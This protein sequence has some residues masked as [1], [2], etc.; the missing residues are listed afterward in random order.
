MQ[1]QALS[2]STGT[3]WAAAGSGSSSGSSPLPFSISLYLIPSSP[4]LLENPAKFNFISQAWIV[5]CQMS[6]CGQPGGESIG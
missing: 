2:T 5:F 4:F 1:A 6:D 3:K